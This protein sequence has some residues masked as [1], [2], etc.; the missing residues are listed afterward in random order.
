MI[1]RISKVKN[2]SV[3]SVAFSSLVQIGDSIG[4]SLH[5]DVLAVQREQPIFFGN[6]GNF[7]IYPLFN[8][9]VSFPPL[10]EEITM[11]VRHPKGSIQVNTIDIVS[12]ISSSALLH[13]GSSNTIFCD[14]RRK[15]IR[16][17][18]RGKGYITLKS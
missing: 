7:Q 1:R 2:V 13:I 17:L 9:P 15:N 8:V 10:F 6:E 18:E 12:G 3:N 14:S 5:T 11:N 16:Q 4:I